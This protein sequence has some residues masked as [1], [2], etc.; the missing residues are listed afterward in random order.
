MKKVK[1]SKTFATH[2][3]KRTLPKNRLLHDYTNT[4]YLFKANPQ[5]P[6][7]RRHKLT[8]EFKTYESIDINGDY[9]II[10][11][12]LKEYYFFIDVGNHRQLYGKKENSDRGLVKN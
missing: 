12:E 8:K 3:K 11:K 2:F 5:D 9:R 6:V 1:Q 10:F 7:L 4:F